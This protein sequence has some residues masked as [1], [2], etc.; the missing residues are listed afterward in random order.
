M[1]FIIS[2]AANKKQYEQGITGKV[3]WYEGNFMPAIGDDAKRSKPV[4]ISRTI[5]IFE[6]ISTE[7]VEITN[8]VWLSTIDKNPVKTVKSDEYGNFKVSLP[9]G[10]YTIVSKEDKGY[11]VNRF[12]GENIINPVI[13]EENKWTEIEVKLD[14]KAA[15]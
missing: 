4:G 12:D 10:K 8:R 7:S 14:Y 2:C 11:Y 3:M 1:I 9:P 6:P 15:F 13:V 5:Y